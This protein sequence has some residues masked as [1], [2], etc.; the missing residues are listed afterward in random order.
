[1]KMQT[2]AKERLKTHKRQKK[3]SQILTLIFFFFQLIL[4]LLCFSTR[5]IRATITTTI[6][7]NRLFSDLL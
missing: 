5:A 3:Q 4:S 6:E 1:M 2:S 7:F